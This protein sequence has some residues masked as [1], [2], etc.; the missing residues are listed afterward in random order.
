MVHMMN[1][2]VAAFLYHLFKDAA[3]PVKFIMDLLR[4]T[5]DATLV[6]EIKECDW[7]LD[8]Q[9]LTTPQEKKE[10]KGIDKLQN[11]EW[12]KNMF[13]LQSLGK[14]TKPTAN[15]DPEALF[16]LDMNNSIKT[17]HNQHLKPTFTL[18]FDEDDKSEAAAPAATAR[19]A[20]P[21]RKNPNK[22]ATS[23]NDLVAEAS[24]PQDEEV[25]DTRVAGGG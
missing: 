13:N 10:D 2:Q 5:C 24:P 14:M 11:A 16:D 12:Y 21:P 15:K 25:G 19:S 23:I 1:K 3:L 6:A 8:T 17:I 4:A 20:T 18:E 22:E 9:T 7:D